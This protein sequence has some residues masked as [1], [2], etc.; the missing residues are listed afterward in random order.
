M[1]RQST[2]TTGRLNVVS[3]AGF[4]CIVLMFSFTSNLRHSTP[5]FEE[6]VK[7]L[8]NNID[9]T[10][11]YQNFTAFVEDVVSNLRHAPVVEHDSHA[12]RVAFPQTSMNGLWLE[13]GVFTGSTIRMMAD[14]YQGAGPVYG[15]DSF[16]GLPEKW[17]DPGNKRYA[18]F[19]DKGG[20]SLKG[21]PPFAETE[22][23]KWV[24]GWY[25]KSIPPFVQNRKQEKISFIH[26]DC[27]LYSSTKTIFKELDAWLEPGVVIVFDE[28][29]NYPEYKEHEIKALFELLQDRPDLGFRIIGTSTRTVQLDMQRE[30]SPQGAAIQLCANGHM[31][32]TLSDGFAAFELFSAMQRNQ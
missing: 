25:E 7:E 6:K 30:L 28:L 17:R 4:L 12:L 27:D 2:K 18:H 23:I 22:K 24:K 3:I 9:K 5:E 21:N 20:F 1:L 32:C 13:F 11:F 10:P 26:V 31:D 29:V 14:A 15:F 19:L 16:E 8:V